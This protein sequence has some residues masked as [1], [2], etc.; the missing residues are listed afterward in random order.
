MTDKSIFNKLSEFRRQRIPVCLATV[1]RTAGSTP[2]KIGA[3]MIVCVDGATYGSIGGGCG[4]NQVRSTAYKSILSVDE[5]KLLEV[6]LT[7]DLGTRG[8]DV[9]GG[10]MWIFIERYVWD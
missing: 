10:K 7:D 9:C 5:P 3:K 8:G 4:E 1:V 2:R 6:D